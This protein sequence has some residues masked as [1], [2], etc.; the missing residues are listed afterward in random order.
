MVRVGILKRTG[1]VSRLC[2]RCSFYLWNPAFN[3]CLLNGQNRGRKP[4]RCKGMLAC[5]GLMGEAVFLEK[6]FLLCFLF[7]WVFFGWVLSCVGFFLL[8]GYIKC[9]S[10][11]ELERLFLIF[12][13]LLKGK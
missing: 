10:A 12:S 4:Q 3:S 2:L 1:H 11:E 7:G 13:T 6:G 5:A 9:I 8:L